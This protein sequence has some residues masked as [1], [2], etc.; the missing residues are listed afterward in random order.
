LPYT[1]V[2]K[3]RVDKLMGTVLLLLSWVLTSAALS[4][5]AGLQS[6]KGNDLLVSGLT[7]LSNLAATGELTISPTGDSY[8]TER[9]EA[10]SGRDL[11]DGIRSDFERGYLFSGLIDP[12]L[13]SADCEFT[14]PTLTFT[15]LSTFQKNIA[16]I[17]PL[18][19]R[20]VSTNLVTLYSL[21]MDE[22]SKRV[23]AKWRMEGNL[24]LPWRPV[25]DVQG[26]TE[27]SFSE[28][29]GRIERYY[30]R[31]TQEPGAALLSLLRPAADKQAAIAEKCRS[32]GSPP[33]ILMP[34]LE[35][36]LLKLQSGRDAPSPSSLVSLLDMHDTAQP[37]PLQELCAGTSW[38]LVYTDAKDGSNG[39][40]GGVKGRVTQKFDGAGKGG[41]LG[42]SNSVT[43][44]SGLLEIDLRAEAV[45]R[46]GSS[47]CD[48]NFM[49]TDFKLGGIV[50]ASTPTKGRGFW[51]MRYC[52]P[53]RRLRVFTTNANSIF[54]L[55]KTA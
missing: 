53:A 45:E 11:F 5:R 2:R 40:I 51:K 49:R 15:G 47:V 13:Y 54:V 48:V 30:E 29:D 50:V 55:E 38:R 8:S 39:V 7:A 37:P 25:I 35:A 6:F 10:V 16:A 32:L 33:A 9:V 43:F 14:D 23:S 19:K 3:E 44:F 12:N 31:W 1:T 22:A 4:A 36:A 42:F 27:Y 20:F 24:A 34:D 28:A 26:V 21:E 41:A 46:P 17:Q 18:I 52:D